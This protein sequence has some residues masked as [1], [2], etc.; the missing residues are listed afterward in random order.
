[1]KSKSLTATLTSVA[2]AICIL[3]G[4]ASA[5]GDRSD[6][7]VVLEWNQ[8]LQETLGPTPPFLSTRAFAML[9]VAMFDAVNSI[10]NSYT[11]Y[12]ARVGAPRGASPDAAAAQAAHDV[13]VALFPASA[14]TYDEAL[15]ERLATMDGWRARQGVRVGK[16]IAR[17]IL[18]WRE[19]DGWEVAPPAYL[20]P[21]LPGLWQ[22]TP[23]AFAAAAF[24]QVADVKP[25]ALITST[26]YL[27]VRPPTLNSPEYADGFNEVKDIGSA[28]STMRTPAQTQLALLFAAVGYQTTAFAIWNNIARDV[29]LERRYSLLEIARLF[30]QLNVSINDGLQ[31]SQT[32]KFVYGFWRPVTAIPRA[33]EDLNPLTTA[34]PTWL[35]LLVT[36]PYPSHAGNMACVG[37]A[38]A[39]TLA[40][41]FGTNDIPVTA[42]WVGSMGNADVSLHYPGFW[43]VAEAEALSRMYGGIHFT[44]EA[45]ASQ[46]S[47]PKVAEFVF[48][49]Y[50]R[51]KH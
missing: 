19:N 46:V 36:P 1:M 40:L 18:A 34:D 9:H 11:R 42:H 21:P 2:L 50:M 39:R 15:A 49:N 6:P 14:A 13:L 24:T 43:A 28:T 10:E 47:C 48:N 5:H 7:A 32:S 51:P 27:P 12:H 33:D 23:P 44:F 4:A 31:T 37:A 45:A 29:A 38:A 35:P 8:L 22:P 26:Q 25:F 17:R 41:N 30:A 3:N 16:A 20:P